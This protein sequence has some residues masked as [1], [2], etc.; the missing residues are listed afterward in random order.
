MRIDKG[1][2]GLAARGIGRHPAAVPELV[3]LRAGKLPA[4]ALR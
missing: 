1:S 4:S 2:I 3:C